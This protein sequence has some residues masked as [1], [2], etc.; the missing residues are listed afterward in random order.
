[1]NYI[2]PESG[3]ARARA[4]ANRFGTQQSV[5]R[6]R[7]LPA[8]KMIELGNRY[9]RAGDQSRAETIFRAVLAQAPNQPAAL[10]SL[11]II[12]R[13]NKLY[14]EAAKLMERT[15]ALAPK[16]HQAYNN[17]GTVYTDLGR[18]DDAVVAYETAID[19]KPDYAEAF[20]N[21][22]VAY[23]AQ[24]KFDDALKA[25]SQ[26]RRLTPKRADLH[27]EIGQCETKLGHRLEAQIAY[28][29]ALHL[30]PDHAQARNGLARILAAMGRYEEAVIEFTRSLDDAPG[31]LSIMNGLAEA[32]KRLGQFDEALELLEKAYAIEPR[33]LETLLNI[34]AVSQCMGDVKVAAV[35]FEQMLSLARGAESAEKSVLFAALNRPDLSSEELFALHL[36]MRSIHDKP[37]LRGKHFDDRSHDP[38]RKLRVGFVSSDFR[39]HVVALNMLPLIGHYDRAKFD[40]ILYAQEKST[41]QLTK[42]FKDHT[43]GYRAIERF[44]DAEVARMIEDDKIDILVI[45]AGRFDENRPLIASHRAAPIQVSFHD[46]ATSGL[47]AMD[48]WLTDSIL[49][50]RDTPEGFT[51]Q[52]YRLPVYYQYPAQDGLPAVSAPPALENGFIT[53]GSFNKP[54]KINEEVVA[55]WA[56][57]LHAVPNSKL[58]L[59][60]FSYYSEPSMQRRWLAKFAD[61]GIGEDRLI[62]KARS[63]NRPN[64][65]TLYNDVDVALDPFPFNGATTTFEAL[66]MCVPVVSL[67]GR[68]FVDRV[69]ASM[70]THAGYP[71]LVAH[72]RPAYVA[73]ARDLASDI[74]R[75]QHWRETMREQLHS[76]PLCNGADYARTIEDAFRDMWKTW[77]ETGGYRGR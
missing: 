37:H 22:G 73:L 9:H 60:Y 49:H 57:V 12:A 51:E 43:Q 11:G 61:H 10:L 32:K 63:D 56:D 40:V 30:K 5:A 17:L 38:D 31:D 28:R 4:S 52:L 71:E 2:L 53:F 76:S 27:Y 23:E 42:T 20:Y 26:C 66:S 7:N 75:L 48:Y 44:D 69:A 36:R 74:G 15:V 39:T 64:H 67:L 35:Y 24:R 54:E 41:D 58:L 6:Q 16:Y 45:L 33:N 1:M 46:C 29:V 14:L 8:S 25:L 21:L 3:L 72:D 62:L 18:F 13:Q 55:V 50:P 68:H 34:G 59:K 65:L 47:E 77:V 19:L 70:V